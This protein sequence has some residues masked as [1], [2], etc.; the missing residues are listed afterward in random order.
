MEHITF[1]SS[2]I[3]KIGLSAEDGSLVRVFFKASDLPDQWL[4]DDAEP[5]L[6]EAGRQLKAYFSGE[7][8]EFDLPLYPGGSAFAQSVL[9]ETRKIP[10]GATA[11]YG[12]IAARVGKPKA[13]RAVGGAL[14]R[15]SLPIV[16]PCHRVLAS[17]GALT[18]YACGLEMKTMLLRLEKHFLE[19]S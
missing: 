1:I 2:P 3:G 19:R 11:S 12:E 14:N 4:R 6:V 18:G 15:N 17:N 8:T 10:Y 9:A 16:I 5:T 13:A 7:L